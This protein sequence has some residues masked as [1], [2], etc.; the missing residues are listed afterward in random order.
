MAVG[1]GTWRLSKSYSVYFTIQT[2]HSTD[3]YFF[4]YYTVNCG[5][6]TNVGLLKIIRYSVYYFNETISLYRNQCY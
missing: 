3:R 2:I 5:I 1:I 4:G 6:K